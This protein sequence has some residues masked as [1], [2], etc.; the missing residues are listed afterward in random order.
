[1]NKYYTHKNIKILDYDYKIDDELMLNN[2]AT[3]KYETP[4]NRPFEIIQCWTYY[5]VIL[6]MDATN[7]KPMLRISIFNCN[8][9]TSVHI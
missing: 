5:T 7:L 6:I 8:L 9:D 2:K 4:Y 1:M 3:Y